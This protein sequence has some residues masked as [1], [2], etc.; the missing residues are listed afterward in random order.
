[1]Q[2]LS[3]STWEAPQT[4]LGYSYATIKNTFYCVKSVSYYD[5]ATAVETYSEKWGGV[6]LGNYIVGNRG[7]YADPS[8]SV[9]QHE[10]GHYLQSQSFGPFYL[11]R[12]GIPSLFDT[13]RSDSDKAKSPHNNH[14]VEQDAN[15]RAFNYFLEYEDGYGKKTLNKSGGW[16]MVSNRIL[17]YK[18]GL[19]YDNPHNQAVLGKSLSLGWPDYVWGTSVIIPGI[20]NNIS[21]HQ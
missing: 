9:F 8:N 13:L 2:V 3:H 7:L 1:M 4:F 10:Y 5:G 6:T 12:C 16:D 14:P 15:I 21:L 17:G 20:I 11:Q 18:T 19:S